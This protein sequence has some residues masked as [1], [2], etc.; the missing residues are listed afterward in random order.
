MIPAYSGQL[1]TDFGILYLNSL[2]KQS[3]KVAGIGVAAFLLTDDI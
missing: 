2:T 3:S 1:R